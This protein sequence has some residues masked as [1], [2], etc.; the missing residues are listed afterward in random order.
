[1]QRLLAEIKELR[2]QLAQQSA[3]P[4]RAIGYTHISVQVQAVST[5]CVRDLAELFLLAPCS[6]LSLTPS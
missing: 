6:L 4:P 1:V 3:P 2:C 5:L